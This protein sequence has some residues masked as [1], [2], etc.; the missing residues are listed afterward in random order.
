MKNALLSALFLL[1]GA[2]VFTGC[3]KTPDPEDTSYKCECGKFTWQGTEYQLNDASYIQW[4]DTLWF[5]RDYYATAELR[6]GNQFLPPNSLNLQ[7][8]FEDIT[9]LVFFA[10]VDTFDVLLQEINYDSPINTIRNFVPIEGVVNISPALPGAT[11]TIS[12]N[13]VVK[14]LVN[15]TPVGFPI[16]FTGSMRIR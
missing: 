1:A 4:D 5:T 15:G 7:M 14:E 11:E 10:D 3:K 8:R 16:P 2:I 13:L 12:F 6:E 9:P